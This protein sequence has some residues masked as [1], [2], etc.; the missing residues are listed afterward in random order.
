MLR[1]Y[2]QENY[3]KIYQRLREEDRQVIELDFGDT[4]DKLKEEY[5]D[6]YDGVTSE[7]LCTTK[8]DENSDLSTMY[9]GRI[10]MTRSDK[11]KVEETFSVSEQGYTIGKLLDGTKCQILLDV[12]A[13]KSF[14]SKCI[15][16]D[17]SHYI[18]YR[19]FHPELRDS[20]RKWTVC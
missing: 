13:C 6:M 11:I 8:F 17:V 9:L 10:D 14:M 7:V 16:W 19:N 1:L 12:G 18:C 5:L 20:G 4:A 3:R 15:I 2:K